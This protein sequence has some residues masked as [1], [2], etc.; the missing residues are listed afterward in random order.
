MVSD[1]GIDSAT[2]GTGALALCTLG[3]GAEDRDVPK[4][5]VLGRAG[6]GGVHEDVAGAPELS[7]VDGKA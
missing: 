7:S 5:G 3:A 6:P 1:E 4:A 2:E